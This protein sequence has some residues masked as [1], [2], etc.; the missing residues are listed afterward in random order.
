MPDRRFGWTQE[1]KTNYSIYGSR[2]DRNQ[3]ETAKI[4]K[5]G[6][7]GAGS[8]LTHQGKRSPGKRGKLDAKSS[9][10]LRRDVAM[11]RGAFATEIREGE[12]HAANARRASNLCGERE[13]GSAGRTASG[14]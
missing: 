3:K 7:P 5:T 2:N 12:S 6:T 8:A 9:R 14:R 11:D 10:S 1:E 4:V 13:H